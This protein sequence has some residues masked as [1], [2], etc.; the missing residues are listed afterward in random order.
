MTGV[1][2][3]TPLQISS[4][5]WGHTP[6]RAGTARLAGHCS[7]CNLSRGKLARRGWRANDRSGEAESPIA[8]ERGAEGSREM[9]GKCN[10][11]LKREAKPLRFAERPAASTCSI[12][13]R[14]DHCD[15]VLSVRHLGAC[16]TRTYQFNMR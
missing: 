16:T 5:G 4:L 13:L 8:S 7:L 10:R 14:L 6:M 3:P 15:D 9:R 2:L 12:S 1:T 11:F